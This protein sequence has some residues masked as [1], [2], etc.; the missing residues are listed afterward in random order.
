[1]TT[2][3]KMFSTNIFTEKIVYYKIDQYKSVF[4]TCNHGKLRQFVSANYHVCLIPKGGLTGEINCICRNV[5]TFFT[6]CITLRIGRFVMM[7]FRFCL[8]ILSWLAGGYPQRDFWLDW[9]NTAPPLIPLL[10]CGK[11]L[12]WDIPLQELSNPN[13]VI[14]PFRNYQNPYM[15]KLS[16]P[17]FLEIIQKM[18]VFWQAGWRTISGDKVVT[19]LVYT[20]LRWERCSTKPPRN[21]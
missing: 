18:C 1:M 11:L 15:V 8:G 6:A 5:A 2:G 14:S 4:G 7:G 20:M 16:S 13:M 10:I 12:E 3:T 21:E 19:I 9:L 17:L